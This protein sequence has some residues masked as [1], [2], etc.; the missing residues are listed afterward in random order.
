MQMHLPEV[1]CLSL[2]AGHLVRMSRCIAAPSRHLSLLCQLISGHTAARTAVLAAKG[3]EAL[4]DFLCSVDVDTV[5]GD[6]G[7][8]LARNMVASALMTAIAKR[9]QGDVRARS[10]DEGLPLSLSS[11]SNFA[12]AAALG[13]SPLQPGAGAVAQMQRG[14]A[15]KQRAQYRGLHASGPDPKLELSEM[16]R[17]VQQFAGEHATCLVQVPQK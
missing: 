5:H 4:L 2:R 3:D 12:P 9:M 11:S 6:F 13:P 16:L 17:R 8:E 10:A 1:D 15:P 14:A 7:L